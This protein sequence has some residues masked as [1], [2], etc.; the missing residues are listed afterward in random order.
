LWDWLPFTFAVNRGESRLQLDNY[1]MSECTRATVVQNSF[2]EM[3]EITHGAMETVAIPEN[4][5]V[6]ISE[7]MVIGCFLS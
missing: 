7:W 5:T 3:I 2:A 1:V 6:I 4:I